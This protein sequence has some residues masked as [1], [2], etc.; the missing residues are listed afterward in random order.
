MHKC[1]N[2]GSQKLIKIPAF[3]AD[4]LLDRM[5]ISGSNKSNINKCTNC[6]FIFGD[7]RPSDIDLGIFYQDYFGEEYINHRRKFEPEFS[8]E[9][10]ASFSNDQEIQRKIHN[11]QQVLK[12]KNLNFS[13]GKVLDFGGGDGRNLNIELFSNAEK[14]I[15]EI[16]HE[17]LQ[18]NIKNISN[19]TPIETFEKFD[20]VISQHTFEHVSY[21]NIIVNKI[22][23]M[24]KKDGYFFVEVPYYGGYSSYSHND[25]ENFSSI[26]SKKRI[27]LSKI[28][29][30]YRD[31]LSKR[32]AQTIKP[33]RIHEHLNHF[34]P[35]SL[36]YLLK[37]TGFV[38]ISVQE[39]TI[40][41]GKVLCAIAK[42]TN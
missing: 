33:F 35:Q 37:Q 28:S 1:I 41:E 20:L 27:F 38:E 5:K 26:F 13:N 11:L 14:F 36:K 15:F 17:N 22:Y 25:N 4:F 6:G 16:S 21:P 9:Q 12:A 42:K 18:Q 24:I 7:F 10:K 31:N 19:Q 40:G 23:D 2:C 3:I 34:N 39:F 29:K 30:K 32:L 8:V